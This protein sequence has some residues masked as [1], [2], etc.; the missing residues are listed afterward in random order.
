MFSA[1]IE[2]DDSFESNTEGCGVGQQQRPNQHN[3]PMGVR[4][5]T[6]EETELLAVCAEIGQYEIN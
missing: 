3:M 1:P 6:V 5:S 4:S 2:K